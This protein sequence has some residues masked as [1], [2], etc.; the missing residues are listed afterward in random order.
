MYNVAFQ[1]YAF[2]ESHSTETRFRL[3][4]MLQRVRH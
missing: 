4:F 1:S 3:S 2:I